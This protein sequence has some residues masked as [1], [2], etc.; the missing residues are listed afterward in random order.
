MAKPKS[1]PDQHIT[2][3]PSENN[4]EVAWEQDP[5]LTAEQHSFLHA[6]LDAA[7]LDAAE[8]GWETAIE[9][10]RLVLNAATDGG[11]PSTVNI[12]T[13]KLAEQ[14]I[15]TALAEMERVGKLTDRLRLTSPSSRRH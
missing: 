8:S 9:A 10:M 12:D 5:T 1:L 6:S 4:P 11:H 2:P 7:C 13:V 3:E 15:N 14:Q